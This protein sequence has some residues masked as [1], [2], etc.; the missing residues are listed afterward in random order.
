MRVVT[1]ECCHIIFPSQLSPADIFSL[2]ADL[3]TERGGLVTA[4]LTGGVVNGEK[5]P[6]AP[7]T[8]SVGDLYLQGETG[9]TGLHVVQH[10]LTYRAPH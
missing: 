1:G 6:G 4:E 3:G 5:Y 8:P 9:L 2:P 10:R 7:D